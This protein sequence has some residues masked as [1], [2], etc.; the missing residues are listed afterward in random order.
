ML[1]PDAGSWCT[2]YKLIVGW[3]RGGTEIDTFQTRGGGPLISWSSLI[4]S[5]SADLSIFFTLKMQQ[6]IYLEETFIP[7]HLTCMSCGSRSGRSGGH[8]VNIGITS[9]LSVNTAEAE[10]TTKDLPDVHMCS[11]PFNIYRKWWQ[12]QIIPRSF[13]GTAEPKIRNPYFFLLPAEL[14]RHVVFLWVA[15]FWRYRL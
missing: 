14:F 10:N 15:E 8:S 1:P 2:F 4:S 13:K 3:V 5:I 12:M 11:L 6:F 7:I 9:Q